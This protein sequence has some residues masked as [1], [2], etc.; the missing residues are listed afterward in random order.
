MLTARPEVKRTYSRLKRETVEASLQTKTTEETAGEIGNF[1]TTFD[2]DEELG[3][4]KVDKMRKI[5]DFFKVK[6]EES[7]AP[8]PMSQNHQMTTSSS[9]ITS[10]SNKLKQTYLDLGQKDLI[11]SKCPDCLMHFN[12]SFPD[13][14][15]LHKKFHSNYLKG[16]NFNIKID[17]EIVTEIAPKDLMKWTKFRFY[18][19]K[20][21][22]GK[23]VKKMEF[24]MNFVHVQLGAEPLTSQELQENGRY[25]AVVV[26]EYSTSKILGFGLFE[27][28]SKVFKSRRNCDNSAIELEAEEVKNNPF[29]FIGVSRIWVDA[30]H[31]CLG[32]AKTL[33]DL[34]CNEKRERVA[35]SQPT[36]S[37]FA[38]AK[39]YQKGHFNA[40][41][42]LIY[43]K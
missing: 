32:L 35:F 10:V 11:S 41:Q 25:D 6:R 4:V 5:T 15:N 9:P 1:S 18:E 43:L 29:D 42:C 19:I 20:K 40:N 17:G 24:F 14:V 22:E 7:T 8:F 23:L 38:F 21:F 36:P 33:L 34:K 30:K 31:R 16:Y 39:S 37:G 2:K 27:K 26:V 3:I 28:C 12:K 13:D